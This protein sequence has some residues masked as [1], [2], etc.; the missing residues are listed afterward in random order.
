MDERKGP[1]SVLVGNM[2]ERD[3]LENFGVD[4]SIIIKWILKKWDGKA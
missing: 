3:H 1:Y 4:K 2:R